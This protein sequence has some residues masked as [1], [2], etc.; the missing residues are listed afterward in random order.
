L[1]RFI[2][3]KTRGIPIDFDDLCFAAV[4]LNRTQI[5]GLLGWTFKGQSLYDEATNLVN[6]EKVYEWC[7]RLNENQKRKVWAGGLAVRELAVVQKAALISI[8]QTLVTTDGLGR[9]A[10]VSL[11]ANERR[12]P[13]DYMLVLRDRNGQSLGWLR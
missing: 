8:A 1:D 7:A 9:A 6:N 12:A 2:A 11:E 3:S 5:R 4:R 10:V 13:P